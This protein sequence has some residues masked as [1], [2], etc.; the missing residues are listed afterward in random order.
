[1]N[2]Q[3]FMPMDIQEI[4]KKRQAF[5]DLYN[6]NPVIYIIGTFRD[7][8]GE[9]AFLRNWRKV[10]PHIVNHLVIVIDDERCFIDPSQERFDGDEP[11]I[12]FTD[13]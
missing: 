4:K 7:K 9:L 3:F 6:I 1:M 10:E 5:I 11:L 2:A 12:M 8:T 13:H